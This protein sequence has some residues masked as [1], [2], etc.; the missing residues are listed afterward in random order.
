MNGKNTP[1]VF[2]LSTISIGSNF[3]TL[4]ES[5]KDV[6]D[7]NSTTWRAT[8]KDGTECK[9]VIKDKIIS[10]IYND[11]GYYKLYNYYLK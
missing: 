5:T 10:V 7:D 4:N 6:I 3:Y 2:L 9:I 11:N 1:V 8:D